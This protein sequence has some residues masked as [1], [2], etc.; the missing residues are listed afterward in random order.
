MCSWASS[1]S[2]KAGISVTEEPSQ[3]LWVDATPPP[4]PPTGLTASG[5]HISQAA[6]GAGCSA[7]RAREP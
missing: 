5:G 2:T 7:P 3:T 6:Q 1:V 4:P